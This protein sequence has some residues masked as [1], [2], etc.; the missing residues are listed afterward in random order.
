MPINTGAST[1]A[2]NIQPTLRDPARHP[3]WGEGRR[4][5]DHR[6]ASFSLPS[7]LSRTKAVRN[8]SMPTTSASLNAVA[9]TILDVEG[10][11]VLCFS[12]WCQ[13][14]TNPNSQLDLCII[15]RLKSRASVAC[16]CFACWYCRQS[17]NNNSMC[18]SR[19]RLAPEP[20]PLH[21]PNIRPGRP[22]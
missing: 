18:C 21:V 4:R 2:Q 7:S 14:G 8:S 9:D 10:T 5:P 11:D 13:M 19:F 3:F 15:D 6:D 12:M 1:T 20:L 17:C 22:R 16:F